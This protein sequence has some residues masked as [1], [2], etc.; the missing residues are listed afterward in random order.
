MFLSD[1]PQ[2]LCQGLHRGL[3][4]KMLFLSE[5]DTDIKPIAS[6]ADDSSMV[7][8]FFLFTAYSIVNSLLTPEGAVS[9]LELVCGCMKKKIVLNFRIVL[10]SGILHYEWHAMLSKRVCLM[11]FLPKRIVSFPELIYHDAG[12]IFSIHA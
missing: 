8:S 7:L 12:E 3:W 9:F 2:I 11:V 1:I 10:W 5:E 4:S 6:A